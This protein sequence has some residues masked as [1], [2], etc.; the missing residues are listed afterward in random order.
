MFGFGR[1]STDALARLREDHRRVEQLFAQFGRE[2]QPARQ[3]ALA[4]EICNELTVHAQVEEELFYPA[5]MAAS[6]RPDDTHVLW[7]AT[8][9]HGVLE[10]LIQALRGIDASDPSF[11]GHMR[12]LQ[13]YVEDHVREEEDGIFARARKSGLDLE[14]LGERIVARRQDLQREPGLAQPS[15]LQRNAA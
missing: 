1:S 4:S 11:I 14:D 8:V 13:E 3:A 5:V 6:P 15:A 12:V 7:E 9:E 2:S 10:G